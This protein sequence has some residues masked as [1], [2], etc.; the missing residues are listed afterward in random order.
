MESMLVNY[1]PEIR[2]LPERE[3]LELLAKARYDAFVVQKL[4]GKAAGYFLLSILVA[5]M[6]GIGARLIVGGGVLAQG[7]FTGLGIIVGIQIH[8]RLY[9]H[10]LSQG[11][12]RVISGKNS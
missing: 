12:Q 5:A 7:A 2:D 3:Q 10:L 4:G 11:L 6:I 8:K 9:A 1:F